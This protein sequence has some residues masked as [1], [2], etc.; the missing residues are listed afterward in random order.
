[1]A[2]RSPHS[3]AP[4]SLSRLSTRFLARGEQALLEIAITG[5][6]PAAFPG[7]PGSRQVWR[8]APPDA[9]PQTQLMPGQTAGVCL[10]IPRLEL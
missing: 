2:V 10:R 9:A 1:M 3:P 8:S 4:R 5:T 7:N 6:Q